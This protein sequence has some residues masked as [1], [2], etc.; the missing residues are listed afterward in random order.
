MRVLACISNVWYPAIEVSGASAYYLQ[1][2]NL[3]KKGVEVHILTAPGLWDDPKRWSS[4]YY[5]ENWFKKEE[6][7]SK[8]RFHFVKNRLLSVKHIGYYLY[9]ILLLFS[10][11]RLHKKYKF[12]IIH[13]YYSN[14]F[15][16]I[17]GF[18]LSKLFNLKSVSTICS[19]GK[20]FLNKPFWYKLFKQ[21]KIIFPARSLI[22]SLGL[23]KKRI[24]YSYLPFGVNTKKRSFK[25]NNKVVYI[26]PL[27]DR[28]GYINFVKSYKEVKKYIKD[29]NFVIYTSK[30]NINDFEDRLLNIKKLT[31]N[32][33]N[34]IIKEGIF[35][36]YQMFKNAT[37]YVHP[38]VE[39]HGTVANPLTLLEAMSFGLPILAADLNEIKEIKS[40][41][42]LLFKKED[43][44]DLSNKIVHLLNNNFK[45]NIMSKESSA[46]IKKYDAD[47]LSNNLKEI[48]EGVING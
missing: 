37:I 14:S 34:F 48:Y 27:L 33:K 47:N 17:R 25:L 29:V 16:S 1:Q 40:N 15:F 35:S 13:D 11:I 46:F 18:F 41:G 3:V 36:K 44:K 7:T 9:K 2:K 22:N 26:G 23:A 38:Q 28:K 24:N 45:L 5:D 6:K 42:I 39:S 31:N 20:G 21:N 10:I 43:F 30:Y 8:V 32:S 12:D 4:F 19:E